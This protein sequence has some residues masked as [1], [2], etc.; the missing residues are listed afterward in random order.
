MTGVSMYAVMWLLI[1]SLPEIFPILLGMLLWVLTAAVWSKPANVLMRAV[2]P[3]SPTLIIYDNLAAFRK[4][5]AISRTVNWKF[6]VKDVK[7]KWKR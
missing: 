6:N 1:R 2:C 4:G 7:R 3:P 5:E